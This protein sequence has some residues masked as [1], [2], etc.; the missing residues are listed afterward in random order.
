MRQALEGQIDD[1]AIVTALPAQS[2]LQRQT[3]LQKAPSGE[4]P[5]GPPCQFPPRCT[6]RH[7]YLV[8]LITLHCWLLVVSAPSLLHTLSEERPRIWAPS[9]GWAVISGSPQAQFSP[10]LT[11]PKHDFILGHHGLGKQDS[12]QSNHCR[13][14]FT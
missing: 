8:H 4:D 6:V 2:A 9:W 7:M 12:L 13:S 14:L 5:Q 3:G 1:P 10:R 11:I